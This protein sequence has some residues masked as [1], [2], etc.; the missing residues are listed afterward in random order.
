MWKDFIFANGSNQTTEGLDVSVSGL[1]ANTTY[2]VTI[3]A[4]DDSSGSGRSADWTG[5]NGGTTATLTFTEGDPTSLSDWR[6]DITAITDGA[7]VFT[8]A[9]RSVSNRSA[10][11]AHNVF[12][13]GLE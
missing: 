5:S 7:G 6:I 12:I 13:N 2:D 1:L 9:G 8:L 10:A 11:Q 4:F 3:W